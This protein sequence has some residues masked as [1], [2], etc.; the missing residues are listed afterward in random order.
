MSTDVVADNAAFAQKYAFPFPLLS[1]PERMVCIAYGACEADDD[2]PAKRI[3]FLIGPDGLLEQIYRQV[4]PASHIDMLL[5]ALEGMVVPQ[6]AS[7]GATTNLK[8]K[9]IMMTNVTHNAGM[10]AVTAVVPSGRVE[11]SENG[12]QLIYAFGTLGYDFGTDARYNSFVQ[13]QRG[14]DRNNNWDFKVPADF[15]NHLTAN[16]N[17]NLYK[18]SRVIWTL[19]HDDVPIYAIVPQG[20]FAAATYGRLV[21]YLQQQHLD[22]DDTEHIER[23]SLPGY[24]VSSHVTLKSGQRVP[25]VI[26]EAH[27]L[28]AWHINKRVDE[29]VADMQIE[30]AA[31][32]AEKAKIKNL[33]QRVY[34]E[35]RNMGQDAADRALNYAATNAFQIA[36]IYQQAHNHTQV[37]DRLEV[38]ST[39][40]CRPG[41]DCWIVKLT[42][43]NPRAREEEARRVYQLTIDVSDVVPVTVGQVKSWFMY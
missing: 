3:T 26:P 41:S 39:S 21:S 27:G 36:D 43:F 40:V 12:P 29:I 31:Q 18:A 15:V 23:I 24:L 14:E 9:E 20:P 17:R 28:S 11:A 30:A 13:Y 7:S 35:M 10:E 32:D 33:L 8:Q 4:D 38:E 42:F 25:I 2:Q 34:H 19:N 22:A 6:W 1:D 37:L 16:D 5:E